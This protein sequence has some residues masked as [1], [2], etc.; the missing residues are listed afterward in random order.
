MLPR[1]SQIA[2]PRHHPALPYTEI[3]AF[4]V[5]LAKREGI[6]ARAL[7]FT[8]LTAARTGEVIGALW[9]EIDL[10]GAV[11]TVPAHRMKAGKEHRVPLSPKAVSILEELPQ[12]EDG[13]YV[14]P[15][16]RNRTLPSVR[17]ASSW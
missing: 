8:I 1:R 16:G 9:G 6:A 13:G 4:M 7:E 15:G 5:E 3:P 10:Q 17:I 2:K 14:F 12:E 11:W